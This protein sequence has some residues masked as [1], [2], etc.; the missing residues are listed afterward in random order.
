M[1]LLKRAGKILYK[2]FVSDMVNLYRFFYF[3]GIII[4]ELKRTNLS[5]SIEPFSKQNVSANSL[6]NLFIICEYDLIKSSF[7]SFA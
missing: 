1:V 2:K 5:Q 4:A 7:L 6:V 3:S